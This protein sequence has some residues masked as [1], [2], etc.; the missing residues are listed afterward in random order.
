[1]LLDLPDAAKEPQER[2]KASLILSRLSR[3][4]PAAPTKGHYTRLR[5]SVSRRLQPEPL[6]LGLQVVGA[7]PGL[8]HLHHREGDGGRGQGRVRGGG[9]QGRGHHHTAAV[10][11]G[12]EVA[13]EVVRVLVYLVM[14]R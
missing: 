1:M 11:K 6:G 13:M 2:S 14:P 10:R 5:A 9:S 12:S 7:L 3:R 8:P 4:C